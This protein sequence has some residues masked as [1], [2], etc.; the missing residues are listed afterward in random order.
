MNGDIETRG[1]MEFDWRVQEGVFDLRPG[2]T[3]TKKMA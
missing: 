3:A 2:P 1:S